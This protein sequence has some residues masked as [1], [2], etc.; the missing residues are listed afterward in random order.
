MATFGLLLNAADRV[1]LGHSA[2][3]EAAHEQQQSAR[4][5]GRRF[6]A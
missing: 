6:R 5:R 4:A 3:P 2:L 1:R